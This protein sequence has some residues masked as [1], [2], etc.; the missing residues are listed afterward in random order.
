[1]S[2]PA[3]SESETAVDGGCSPQGGSGG[4]GR[5]GSVVRGHAVG[6]SGL[7]SGVALSDCR[8]CGPGSRCQTVQSVVRGHAGGSVVRGLRLTF[9][10]QQHNVSFHFRVKSPGEASAH[11]LDANSP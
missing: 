2:C 1:M 5:G 11:A 10:Q 8:V 6:L 3:S 4:S 9:P 7:W